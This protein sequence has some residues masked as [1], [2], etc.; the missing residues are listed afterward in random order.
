[1]HMTLMEIL[2]SWQQA[3]LIGHLDLALASTLSRMSG[4]TEPMLLLPALLAQQGM[5]QG[6]SY[7]DLKER[8]NMQLDKIL[9]G[10]RHDFDA[11]E[12]SNELQAIRQ[13]RSPSWEDWRDMLQKEP[14]ASILYGKYEQQCPFVL[15]ESRLYIRRFR[16]YEL[17]IIAK[18]KQLMN[19]GVCALPSPDFSQT[20]Y[21]SLEEEQKAALQKALESRFSIISG[22]PGTGKTHT[23][24][25]LVL[26]LLQQPESA[27]QRLALAAPTGKAATRVQESL[28]KSLESMMQ[29][30]NQNSIEADSLPKAYT[31]HRLLGSLPNSPYFKHDADNPLEL[32]LLMVDEA[33]MIDLPLM[34]KML[35][36]LPENARLVLLGDASQLASVEPGRVYGDLC[37]AADKQGSVLQG[38]LTELVRSRRFPPDSV[39]GKASRAIKAGNAELAWQVISEENN[40]PAAEAGAR[41]FE[42]S[43]PELDLAKDR[44]F[45]ELVKQGYAKF[46]AAKTPLEALRHAADFIALTPRR[47]G[48]Y[49]VKK[50]N[51]IILDILSGLEGFNPQGSFFS[52]QLIMISKNTPEIGLFNGDCGV[53]FPDPEQ[54]DRLCVFFPGDNPESLKKLPLPRLPEHECAFALTIHKS[55]GSEFEQLAMILPGRSDSALLSRELL[56]TGMTRSKT[57]F[58]LWSSFDNFQKAVANQTTRN[59]GLY[60]DLCENPDP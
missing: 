41:L 48:P 57:K 58:Y 36:A 17:D 4:T 11:E 19:T 59:S 26:H 29:T 25:A 22:G 33:S 30:Q 16:G 15:I 56:Y 13:Q 60:L 53:V 47:S 6:N 28:R 34:A 39:I 7:A 40:K 42:I 54:E 43:G 52:H 32:D 46:L 23:L 1:M 49:G 45:H 12:L 38:C 27:G 10:S 51:Q 50:L 35:S 9:Q 5:S 2:K 37:R 24:A 18:S 44:D 14:A 21:N 3:N 31:I 8:A 20:P 55:Q